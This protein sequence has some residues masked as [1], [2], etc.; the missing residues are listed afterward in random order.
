VWFDAPIGY[1]SAT[2]GLPD[3]WGTAGRQRLARALH[4]Q[5]TTSCSAASS[6][7]DAEARR[8]PADNVPASEFLN[9]EGDKISTSR[10]WAVWLHGTCWTSA[11][12]DVCALRALR[13][14]PR[15][16]DNDFTWK[17]LSGPQQQQAGGQPRQQ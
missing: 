3:T 15:N 13:Q 1:I 4:Q 14:R 12:A 5:T 11:E 10:N 16:Q 8:H 6:S 2:K 9:L 7:G 17:R